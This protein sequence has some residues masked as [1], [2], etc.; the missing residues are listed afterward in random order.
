MRRSSAWAHSSKNLLKFFYLISYL[1]SVFRARYAYWA[2]RSEEGYRSHRIGHTTPRVRVSIAGRRAFGFPALSLIPEVCT[3]PL[4]RMGGI[5]HMEVLN[6]SLVRSYKSRNSQRSRTTRSF[7]GSSPKRAPH[8]LGFEKINWSHRYAHGGSLRNFR[9]G[10]TARAIS[11]KDPIHLVFKA[12]RKCVPGGLRQPRRFRR[13]HQLCDRYAKRF[14]IKLDKM[15]IQGDHIHIL[16]RTA[17]RSG[18]QNFLRVFAGQIAQRFEA[19]G[20]SRRIFADS[21]DIIERRHKL[22]KYRPFTRVVK[23]RRA[24]VTVTLY[25][26]LNEQEAQG[27]IP[28]RK[29]RLRGIQI[30]E[31][32]IFWSC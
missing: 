14:F 32:R 30:D 4:E 25:V 18:L 9:A 20:L 27:K 13:I 7:G 31:W 22:W 26:E 12:N 6:S 24:Y 5:G 8:Q 10:R 23:G 28:Y 2:R 11:S 16:V 29:D 17:K 21:T 1:H 19:E 15:S 3:R